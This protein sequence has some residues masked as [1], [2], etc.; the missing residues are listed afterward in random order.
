MSRTQG[1]VSLKIA[2][3][4]LGC[5]TSTLRTWD[6]EGSLK[7]VRTPGGQRRYR[8]E[9]LEAFQ[10]IVKKTTPKSEAVAA[11][12]RVSSHE[13]KA[14]GDLERQK[15]RVLTY[16][17]TKKY[18]V[19][20]AFEEVGSG[21]TDTRAKML[22]LFDLAVKGEIGRVVVEHKDRL[23]RFN[24]NIF[25]RFFESHGVTV[26]WIDDVLP[27][28]YEAELVEDMVSLMASFSAKVYGK[29]SAENRKRKKA[30]K[31]GVVAP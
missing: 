21:M 25:Q 22:R 14:K 24:F 28:S 20:H 16:C 6:N 9:D 4:I 18:N 27:K 10:G 23:A 13:Q 3:E 17:V 19:A 2:A 30:E 12:C 5:G 29:R 26:E 8:I 7:A 1:L 11:Y 31:K 15:G